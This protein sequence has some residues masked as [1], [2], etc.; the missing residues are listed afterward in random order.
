[1]L[2]AAIILIGVVSLLAVV[3]LRQE[4]AGASGTDTASLVTTGR[5]PAPPVDRAGLAL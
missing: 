4:L 3:T 2:E 1:V 5:S